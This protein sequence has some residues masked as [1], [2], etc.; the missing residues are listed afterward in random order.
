MTDGVSPGEARRPN[1]ARQMGLVLAALFAVLALTNFNV[2]FLGQTLVASAN[3]SPFDNRG[4]HLRPTARVGHSFA[5][6]HDLGG[7]WWQWEPAAVAFSDAFRRGEVPLWDP[8][9]A[10]G[11]DA[12]VSLFASQYFP[13][14]LPVL[15]LGDTPALRDAYYL[16]V[17]LAAGLGMAGLLLRNGFH[18]ASATAGGMAYML[19]GAVTQTANSNLGQATAMLPLTLL[20]ADWL[21]ERPSGPRFAAT[22]AVVATSLLAGFLP[23]VFSGFLLV[24]LLA[25]AHAVVPAHA[26]TGGGKVL[27]RLGP[28]VVA[29]GAGLLGLALAAFLILP[30]EKASAASAAFHAWYTGLGRQAYPRYELLTLVSPLLSWDVNQNQ[31]DTKKVFLPLTSWQSHLF[32]VGLVVLLL[33]SLAR[34]LERPAYRRLFLAFGLMSVVVMAKLFGLPPVQWLAELPVL[35][36]THFIPYFCGALAVG[37]SGLA[38]CGVESI[39]CHVPR[40]R[41]LLAGAAVVSVVL[42][43]VALFALA[44]GFN[45][46]AQGVQYLRWAL[47]LDRVAAAAVGILV[48]VW[49]RRRGLLAGKTTGFVAVG[50]VVLE[51]GPLAYHGRYGRADVWRDVPDY[52]RFL[53]R[54]KEPFRIHGVQDQALPPNVFQAMGLQGIGSRAVFNQARFSALVKSSFTTVENSSFVVP[55]QL[56]PTDRV[57]LDLL[58]V[59]YV[60][61]QAPSAKERTEL[62]AAGL[63]EVSTDG[64]FV[65]FQNPTCWP[66]AYLARRYRFVS[67]ASAALEHVATLTGPDEVILEER[68]TF[69]SG[70]GSAPD[71]GTCRIADYRADTVSLEVDSPGPAIAVLLDSFAP[72]WT[73]KVNGAPAR[74]VAANSA[75]RGVEVPAGHSVVTMQ[76]RTPGLRLGLAISELALVAVALCLSPVARRSPLAGPVG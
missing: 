51:L 36:Y 14:Y 5:N 6:W 12:H 15:L 57:V 30:V 69:A 29:A 7:T 46:T 70:S 61:A 22:A 71:G 60:V 23:V 9:M 32:Y 72:G 74:I 64:T 27:R 50:L 59:K 2:V 49:L 4:T 45:P 21:L 28:L 39:V 58:N 48:L 68:P 55:T 31:L 53:Q 52:V 41:D 42:G 25:L 62:A 24:A 10:G 44:R 20:V 19:C 65:I 73:A 43:G 11:V 3:Y 76:Y 63:V 40:R 26:A 13:P 35:R 54:D 1:G 75:F 33:A 8:A 37:L 47:E 16:A 17:I 18:P 66:R 56:L 67:S 34:L 38:A